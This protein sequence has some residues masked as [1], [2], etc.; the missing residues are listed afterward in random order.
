M[1]NLDGTE[2]Q[3]SEVI[4]IVTAFLMLNILVTLV[5]T[6][7]LLEER[8]KNRLAS[9]SPPIDQTSVLL[10]F[11]QTQFQNTK[12]YNQSLD[13]TRKPLNREVVHLRSA[14]LKIEEK[15][16][17]H[18][19][20]SSQYWHYLNDNLLKL[21]KILFPHAV[22]KNDEIAALEARIAGLKDRVL[23]ISH[24]NSNPGIEQHKARAIAS[25]EGITAQH[26]EKRFDASTLEAKLRK[27]ENVLDVFEDPEARRSHL[28]QKRQKQYIARSEQQIG[29]LS[30]LTKENFNGIESLHKKLGSSEAV[31]GELHKFKA[32]NEQ[33]S[34]Q[35]AQLKSELSSFQNKIQMAGTSSDSSE[36]KKLRATAIQLTDITDELIKANELEIERLRD[37]IANQRVSMVQME[38]N[39]QL[40]DAKSRDSTLD[41][42]AEIESL[43]RCIKESEIC[44]NMLEN[45]LN[46][47]RT[48]VNSVQG[49][50]LFDFSEA[51]SEELSNEVRHLREEIESSRSQLGNYQQL[52]AYSLEALTASSTE[53]ISL[54]LYET[55]SGLQ[56]SS[57]LLVKS[58]ER[59]LELSPQGS[60]AVR[61]KVMINNMQIG[62]VNPGQ[63]GRLYFRM[64]NIAGIVQSLTRDTMNESE[65]QFILQMLNTTDK[66]ISL[67]NQAHKGKLQTRMRDEA[68][69]S[70][71]HIC[72]D[73]DEMIKEQE[74]ISERLIKRNF[75]QILE[76][77]RARGMSGTQVA[78]FQGIAQET[79]KQLGAANTLR[80][81]SRKR[82]LSLMSELE[83]MH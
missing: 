33:L 78:S 81:K 15:A 39:L 48:H 27:L 51:E 13:T 40:M 72:S 22:K 56:H 69:N 9:K 63:G 3:T 35:I 83:E 75:K 82:F 66:V 79:L 60:L 18:R 2:W 46:E 47:L 52:L 16:I 61:E 36:D 4:W 12:S 31:A 25:L 17:A 49:G 38:D 10:D 6:H 24:G 8:R 21:V 29:L 65:Q 7:R 64:L 1:L 34:Q 14:Y 20:G 53:D 44:I 45:E 19:I 54:L 50:K 57:H 73:M 77:A 70:I 74:E 42:P 11:I 68:V 76:L 59:T 67:L 30:A 32:E 28:I 43:Q 41:R 55:I 37:V 5:I 58:P 71:R 80:L 62:E 23:A 26:I